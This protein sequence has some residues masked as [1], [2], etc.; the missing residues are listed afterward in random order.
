MKELK[1]G[2][3]IVLSLLVFAACGTSEGENV[4]DDA[5]TAGAS[6]ETATE[7]VPEVP[8]EADDTP[9]AT[10]EMED[11]GEIT[12]ELYPEIAPISVNNFV[13]LAED[14]FY[15]GLRFH[16]IIEG[17]MIQGGDQMGMVQADLDTALKVNLKAMALKMTLVMSGVLSMARSQGMDTAGSQ[18]FIVHGD[19]TYLDGDYAAFGKVIDGMDI[20]D[21]I[22]TV[23]KQG[24]SPVAGQEQVIQSIVI[25]R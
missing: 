20:V 13:A 18:F 14:G 11:G 12:V 3:L 2:W 15:D 16:R 21:Q 22:A 24:E 23:D 25:E 5:Q 4:D 6:N 7:G 19:A 1:Y 8:V 10:I 17:F 9:I